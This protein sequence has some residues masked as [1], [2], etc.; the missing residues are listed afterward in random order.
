MLTAFGGEKIRRARTI[1]AEME[2]KADDGAA[3]GEPPDQDAR[4]ELLRGDVR[5]SGIEGQHDRPVEPGRSQQP[6]FGGL[7]GQ[8][9]QRFAGIE[10]SARMRLEGQHRGG[11][12]EAFGAVARG[13]DHRPMAAVHPV[14]IA[15]GEDGATQRV[16]GRS[17]AHDEE[18]FRRHRAQWLRKLRAVGA[19]AAAP[20]QAPGLVGV[21]G[22]GC[23]D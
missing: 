3:D 11:L 10:E 22:R 23:S 1:L 5:Q 6:Q 2:V 14:E 9:K 19:V 16:S 17:I 20:S 21:V 18:A 8:P 4:D 13:C 7:V 15:D 12:A